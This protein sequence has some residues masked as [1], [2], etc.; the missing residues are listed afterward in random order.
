[1][2]CLVLQIYALAALHAPGLSLYYRFC[3]K[4]PATQSDKLLAWV[5]EGE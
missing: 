1:M 5:H 3:S 4:E 2:E